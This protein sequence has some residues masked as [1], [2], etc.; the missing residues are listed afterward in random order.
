MHQSNMCTTF[1]L[2]RPR[3]DTMHTVTV[4]TMQQQHAHYYIVGSEALLPRHKRT[5]SQALSSD[6]RQLSGI[7]AVHS[8]RA[9]PTRRSVSIKSPLRDVQRRLDNTQKLLDVLQFGDLHQQASRQQ[10]GS[11]EK[12]LISVLAAQDYRNTQTSTVRQIPALRKVPE[13]QS[14][15][16]PERRSKAK[17]GA[18]QGQGSRDRDRAPD[19]Y[20]P[21]MET[22]SSVASVG[23]L[24]ES[25]LQETAPVL[26]VSGE[27]L[28]SQMG[29]DTSSP[30]PIT[31]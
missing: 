19:G 29:G 20:V 2:T 25:Q 5:S 14:L 26:R 18:R 22:A 10:Q 27:V 15:L 11:Q 1:N 17:A 6:D 3:D 8:R 28:K 31:M 21:L 7:K 9:S 12:Y 30:Q 23:L 16:P 13:L 24:E 4:Q